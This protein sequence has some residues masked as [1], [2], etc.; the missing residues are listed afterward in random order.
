MYMLEMESMMQYMYICFK[1]PKLNS[2]SHYLSN[3]V[4]QS[5]HTYMPKWKG[6]NQYQLNVKQMDLCSNRQ[7]KSVIHTHIYNG[8]LE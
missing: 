2:I 4:Y 5:E 6:T 3:H 8:N 7:I 1:M